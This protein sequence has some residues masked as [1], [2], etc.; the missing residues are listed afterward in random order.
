MI[1]CAPL[2]AALRCL[3]AGVLASLAS[4]SSANPATP[5][6]SA[7]QPAVAAV[8]FRW[9]GFLKRLPGPPAPFLEHFA[10]AT[11]TA[12][13][14]AP[15]QTR[16]ATAKPDRGGAQRRAAA[17]AADPAALL[18]AVSEAARGVMGVPSLDPDASLME[19]GLDSLGAVELRNQLSRNF[20]MEL[21]ATL[22]FDYPSAAAVAGYVAGE[23]AAAAGGGGA[24]ATG[25]RADDED[26]DYDD[27][28]GIEED[29]MDAEEEEQAGAGTVTHVAAAV[30]LGAPRRTPL[31][32]AASRQNR[33]VG[34]EVCVWGGA[35]AS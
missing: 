22:V 9:P 11:A 32:A 14:A 13:A 27:D 31:G 34:A 35:Q 17:S 24:A 33:K 28:D 4:A 21:P 16:T 2:R 23:L 30:R 1:L 19:A 7:P 18:E 8:P 15:P 12:A 3:P 6:T 5:F 29:E 26:D 20:K 25:L 10:K